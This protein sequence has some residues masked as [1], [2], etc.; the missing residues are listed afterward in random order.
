MVCDALLSNSEYI[1]MHVPYFKLITEATNLLCESLCT[2]W[3]I[4]VIGG[5]GEKLNYVKKYDSRDLSPQ[6][7]ALTSQISGGRSVGIVR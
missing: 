4:H 6:K 1:Y 5:G 3:T 7:L 2:V